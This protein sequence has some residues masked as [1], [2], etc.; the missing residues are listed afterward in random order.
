L[1]TPKSSSA[2]VTAIVGN[3]KPRS[4]TYDVALTCARYVGDALGGANVQAV[5]LAELG[6]RLLQWGDEEVGKVLA[7]MRASTVLVVASPTYKATYTGL[8]KLLFDQVAAGSLRDI[9]AFPLMVGGA[10][11]HALAVEVHLRPLLVEVG[12]TCVTPGLFVLES[13]LPTVELTVAEWVDTSRTMLASLA[14]R[15]S[16][17]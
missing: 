14:D 12:C 5:D 9:V 10:P 11:I 2:F 6:S 16:A 13:E 17:G 4:R 1:T 3:P 7:R 8:L 15:P